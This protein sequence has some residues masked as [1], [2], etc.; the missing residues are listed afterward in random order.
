[1]KHIVRQGETLSSI[2]EKYHLSVEELKALNQLQSNALKEGQHL[3]VFQRNDQKKTKIIRHKVA[4]GET[5]YIIAKKYGISVAQLKEMNPVATSHI[6]VGQELLIFVPEETQSKESVPA[7]HK[8][9]KGETLHSI[10]QQYQLSVSNLVKWNGLTSNL[11]TE[12]Q[13]L[14][15]SEE[16]EPDTPN[17][18]ASQEL[19]VH[20][21]VKGDS[22]I[23]ISKKYNL[24]VDQ[25]KE[26]NHLESDLLT[27][28]Q[29]LIVSL[30]PSQVAQWS[31]EHQVQEGETLYT[32][33]RKYGISV[34]QLK[35]I[36]LLTQD[37]VESGTLLKI[38]QRHLSSLL[39]SVLKSKE[40][41]D[42]KIL[43]LTPENLMA[44]MKAIIEARKIFQ[45]ETTNGIEIFGSGLRSAVGRNHVNK[46]DDLVKIQRRLIALNILQPNHHENPE[47]LREK[48]GAGAI[49]ANLIPKTIE[50]IERFQTQF[51]VRFWIEHSSRV[52]M[53]KT[54]SYT[55]GVVIPGDITSKILR[56]YTNFTL[57]FPH[58]Q[59]KQPVVVRFTNFPHSN[60]AVYYQGVSYTGNSNPD[61]P[62]QVFERL[63]LQRNLA[64]AVR[65]LSKNSAKYDAINSYDAHIFSY[66]CIG[67]SGN[68]GQLASFMAH[69]KSKAPKLFQEFFQ[70]FGIDVSFTFY[71]DEIRQAELIAINPYDKAGKF[72][73]QGLE[74]ER[75]IR[76]DKQ[77]YGIFIR[78]GHH[79]PF[80]TLQISYLIQYFVRPALQ[81]RSNL[82][83][84]SIHLA[85]I[86]V[87][88][89]IKS[90]MGL[91]LLIE[92]VIYN[93]FN[94]IRDILKE[95]I[96][97]E[98]IEKPYR[99]KEELLQL[100]EQRVIQQII[101][102]AKK[103]K[104][105]EVLFRATKIMNSGLS[106]K[107]MDN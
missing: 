85:N 92:L 42:E 21:A 97:K 5:F 71:Q 82:I 24:T 16:K 69:I 15:I 61:I 46:P 72:F 99:N 10:A 95:A 53:M 40:A 11:L 8:V 98:I 28:G 91:A 39:E 93:K 3:Y 81:I 79:L 33:A 13:I 96:E 35:E 65:Y 77:L 47:D 50:A 38:P 90:P 12:G 87:S 32:I 103:R 44:N 58:P 17:P 25:L 37:K 18:T 49:T 7:Q 70:Q 20:I 75:V 62:L 104:D 78:A 41:D 94:K 83:A 6:R 55:P 34:V 89:L 2:A 74:A 54:N 4:S 29:K 1:M 26:I 86:A 64:I 105:N 67:F 51:R 30:P 27:P 60:D 14:L 102:Y 48:M 100:D 36:N 106:L 19:I 76:D 80:I 101:S 68:G 56:E 43:T 66:G 84:G 45:L 107:K 63:G 9:K 57:T 73:Y 31:E 23:S 59:E 52:A 88:D 22:I